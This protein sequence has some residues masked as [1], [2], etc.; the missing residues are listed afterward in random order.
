MELIFSI[1]EMEGM[2][3]KKIVGKLSLAVSTL[4]MGAKLKTNFLTTPLPNNNSLSKICFGIH[5][6]SEYLAIANVAIAA[7]IYT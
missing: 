1:A 6:P 2:T 4:E 7:I 3:W 5:S